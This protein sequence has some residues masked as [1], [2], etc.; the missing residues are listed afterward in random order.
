MADEVIFDETEKEA[1]LVD[2]AKVDHNWEDIRRQ[3]DRDR[4]VVQR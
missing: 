1:L 4:C 2:I 3:R